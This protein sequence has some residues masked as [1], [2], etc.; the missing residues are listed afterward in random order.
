MTGLEPFAKPFIG[1]IVAP[2]GRKAVD[3]VLGGEH[4]RLLTKLRDRAIEQAAR[5][6]FDAG[7]RTGQQQHL[8]GLLDRLLPDA[9]ELVALDLDDTQHVTVLAVEIAER[10]HEVPELDPRTAG[11]RLSPV[12]EDVLRRFQVAL[13]D[14]AQR[15]RSPLL[16]VATLG[17]LDRIADRVRLHA[18]QTALARVVPTP[19][20]ALRE[21]RTLAADGWLRTIENLYPTHP[22][23]RLFGSSWPMAVL[24]APQRQW[25]DLES[26]LGPLID[27]T[28]PLHTDYPLN[29]Y[30][31][32]K[33]DFDELRR[34]EREDTRRPRR[35]FNGPTFELDDRGINPAI[36]QLSCRPGRYFPMTVTCDRLERELLDTLADDPH[37]VV[38]L[39]D[40][41]RRS[42]AH[43]HCHGGDPVLSGAG[44]ASAVSV[45]TTILMR[46]PSG[47]WRVLLAPRSADVA[48]HA[49]YNH[50]M[51]SGILAPLDWHEGSL[52]DE[53]SVERNLL[54]EYSEEL[55]SNEDLELGRDIGNDVYR[56][57]EVQRL[58]NERRNAV[59]EFYYTGVSVN[60][61]TLR[62]EICTLILVTDPGWWDRE[63]RIADERGPR[64]MRP[65]WEWLQKDEEHLL[66]RNYALFLDL[67]DDFQPAYPGG[68]AAVGPGALVGNAA[69]SM[70]LAFEVARG[71]TA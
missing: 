8:T 19:P 32:G 33:Q 2:L 46:S 39:A 30:P 64:S 43:E 17:Q 1:A 58:L 13:R 22:P 34:R 56:V 26:P 68:D 38:P 35:I 27:S 3:F 71:V 44:R 70:Y 9:S 14:E 52:H 40:L 53:Y 65:G 69:A 60:L 41:P 28:I 21:L 12:I 18:V 66:P 45:A 6:Q 15:P 47:G 29:Y 7:D 59:L 57:A 51:P 37:A 62:P 20:A 5:A 48:A 55:F 50:V 67:D 61:F 31:P 25:S 42:W 10:M 16:G 24:A 4:T 63:S 36:P 54:R 11:V 49:L 23:V